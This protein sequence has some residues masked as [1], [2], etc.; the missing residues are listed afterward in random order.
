VTKFSA[1]VDLVKKKK[2]DPQVS[3]ILNTLLYSQSDTEYNETLCC[4]RGL[5]GFFV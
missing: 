3:E 5:K 1:G 4:I 2:R